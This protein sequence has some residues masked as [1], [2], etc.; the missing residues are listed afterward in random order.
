MTWKGGSFSPNE[1]KKKK[2][3]NSETGPWREGA[4]GPPTFDGSTVHKSGHKK[5]KKGGGGGESIFRYSKPNEEAWMQTLKLVLKMGE[6]HANSGR[7]DSRE[8]RVP[9]NHEQLFGS[10]WQVNKY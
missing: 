7:G 3:I 1:K 2:P 5:K 6:T 8:M 4:G 10:R 9:R